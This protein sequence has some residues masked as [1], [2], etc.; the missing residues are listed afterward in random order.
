MVKF[1]KC[2]AVLLCVASSVEAG[3]SRSRTVT[4][5]TV[6]VA[7]VVVSAPA[8]V[9]ESTTYQATRSHVAVSRPR[10]FSRVY[11]SVPRVS[12]SVQVPTSSRM[13]H[14]TRTRVRSTS[15]GCGAAGCNCQ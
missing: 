10:V 6:E 3:V 13:V 8:P 11:V 14:S 9:V 12:V 7:P 1:L 2:V 15:C 5:E 4:T